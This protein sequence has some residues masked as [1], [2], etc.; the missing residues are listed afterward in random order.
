VD[1]LLDSI[2]SPLAW[3]LVFLILLGAVALTVLLFLLMG[4]D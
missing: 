1:Y 4:D 2:L 3:I